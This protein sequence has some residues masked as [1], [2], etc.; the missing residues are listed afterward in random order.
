MIFNKEIARKTAEVL[1]QVHAI[2]LSTKEP[3]TWAS[4]WKSPIYCDN[5][6]ILSF[7]PIRNYIR[8]AMGKEI[9]KL[10][11][12]PDVIAGVATGAIGIGM[13]VAE[14]L[15]LPFIYVRPEAKGHGRM[16]QIEGFVQTGQNVVVV[17]DLISTGK[18]SLNAVKALKEAHVNVKGMVAI[19]S[20]GFAVA[21]ENF[22]K[23]NITLHTLSNY[24]SLLE[25]ALA[26][27]YIA[28]KELK[29]L[30]LWNANPSEWNAK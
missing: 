22:K 20:Y 8:E 27:K 5:R 2:K 18:S 24:E 9:E 11:G 30:A 26:T 19:F 25:Q 7:P 13:L 6:I 4:G 1:L 12:K 10:Y 23:E 17:E 16:N 29:T 14:Y 15:G 3:F 28:E 21:T